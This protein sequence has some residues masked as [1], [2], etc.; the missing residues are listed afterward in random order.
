MQKV[1]AHEEEE[2]EGGRG[3]G[4]DEEEREP[5]VARGGLLMGEFG[6]GWVGDG[7]AVGCVPS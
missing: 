6:L 4:R 7:D 2:D 5:A 3:V 1:G